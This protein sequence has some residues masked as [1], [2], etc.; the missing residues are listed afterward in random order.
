MHACYTPHAHSPFGFFRRWLACV[1]EREKIK[2]FRQQPKRV[3]KFP[4]SAGRRSVSERGFK[5][6]LAFAS[7]CDSVPL[8]S[9]LISHFIPG[10]EG[11]RASQNFWCESAP[12]CA[13]ALW[14]FTSAQQFPLAPLSPNNWNYVEILGA[15]VVCWL[16]SSTLQT[17][18]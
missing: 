18:W 6:Y 1:S 10:A 15:A 4:S 13:E 3:H 5:I 2:C 7:W 14:Q 9:H 12:M 17:L 11:G 16:L 8:I